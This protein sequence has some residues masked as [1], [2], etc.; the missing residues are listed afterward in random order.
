MLRTNFVELYLIQTWRLK[1]IVAFTTE[2]GSILWLTFPVA[3]TFIYFMVFCND[4]LKRSQI[5]IS[6]R[7]FNFEILLRF[8]LLHSFIGFKSFKGT[9]VEWKRD[10]NIFLNV[11]YLYQTFV[12]VGQIKIVRLIFLRRV[13]VEIDLNRVGVSR[14]S[15]ESRLFVIY[16]ML[17]IVPSHSYET[18]SLNGKSENT[19]MSMHGWRC[20]WVNRVVRLIGTSFNLS[21]LPTLLSFC[22]FPLLKLFF[23]T[24]M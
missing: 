13:S 11:L 2:V 17:L 15:P 12:Q 3:G 9:L 14:V 18:L 16:V 6:S 5:N 1:Q 4:S 24:T 20:L 22:S 8:F 23:A 19:T 21:E 7:V 10:F